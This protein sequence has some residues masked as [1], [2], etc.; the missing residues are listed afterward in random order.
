MWPVALLF[1]APVPLGLGGV[2]A[3]LGDALEAVLA[4]TPWA[5]DAA[6]WLGSAQTVQ[7]P[8]T[9][10]RVGLIVALGLLAPVLVA[11][12]TSRPGWHRTALVAGAAAI[13]VAVVTLSTGLN[14]G[15]QH[16]LTWWTPGT[17]V[18]L[19][20]AVLLALLL[21]G[22]PP[23]RAAALGLL[24]LAALVV[25]VAQAP[26]DPYYAANLQGWEQGRFIRF[27]GLAKWVGWLWP[28]A[29]MLWLLGRVS[30]RG[31]D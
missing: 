20:A 7:V 30:R 4:D 16:A 24:A 18:A 15:P 14:F 28:Y 2:W 19:A 25:L 3:A 9:R 8:L 21:A 26:G 13:A 27:H 29:A 17:G 1:P 10:L 5:A 12:A 11:F 6:G 31:G 22:V 23:R